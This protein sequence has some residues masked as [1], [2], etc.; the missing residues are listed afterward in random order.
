MPGP[1]ISAAA[2]S[3]R[4]SVGERLGPPDLPAGL[5]TRYRLRWMR[6]RLLLRA[7]LAGPHL[8]PQADRTA[9]IGPGTILAL[10]VLR[11]EAP[12]LPGFLDH[13]RAL[14]VGH[15]LIV[16]NGSRDGG[17]AFLA[18]QPDVSLWT[19]A[20]SYRAA[21]L[22]MD[23]LGALLL[24]HGHGHWC[25]TL[26]A[27]ERLVYPDH[28]SRPL[29]DLTRWLQ[30]RGI[31][32]MAAQ[33]VDLYPKGPISAGAEDPFAAPAWF[34]A[35][36]LVWAPQRRF[37]G[38][39]IH[40]G[41]RRRLFFAGGDDPGPHLGKVPLVRWNRRFVYASGAHVLLPPRLN[42]GF[43][44]R[45]ERPTGAL[46]HGKFAPATLAKAQDA[47]S[48]RERHRG[49]GARYARYYRGIAQD[50]DL[51][52]P[53]SVRLEDWRQLERLGLIRRGDWS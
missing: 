26:D 35:E 37:G 45:L 8:A 19:T 24:R 53:G 43:D 40:G 27:D 47:D 39:A 13:H 23:W 22:G 17:A 10:A 48:R 32:A 30:A 51:W 31:E 52:Q 6:R 34:D 12:L 5:W 29:A 1:G 4:V 9:Q 25:L 15:F 14:G 49:D 20:A 33:L 50:P 44:A 46:L 16:D 21:R 3:V 28:D 2:T 7:A 41:P 36:G 18:A 11:D 42:R 38:I